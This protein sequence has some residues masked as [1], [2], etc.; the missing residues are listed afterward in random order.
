MLFNGGINFQG[1]NENY[2]RRFGFFATQCDG[3]RH[4]GEHVMTLWKNRAAR[5]L[6][7][8][9]VATLTGNWQVAR[10]GDSQDV[11]QPTKQPVDFVYTVPPSKGGEEIYFLEVYTAVKCII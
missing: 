1:Y 2:V 6:A 5:P 11:I 7:W 8:A 10:Q 4:V 3:R 9:T